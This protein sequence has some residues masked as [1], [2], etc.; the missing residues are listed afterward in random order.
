[1]GI[2]SR[3]SC[4]RYYNALRRRMR[5]ASVK[6]SPFPSHA[7]RS[8]ALSIFFIQILLPRINGISTFSLPCNYLCLF[9]CYTLILMN[10]QADF[11]TSLSLR[12]LFAVC[13]LLARILRC[14]ADNLWIMLRIHQILPYS[15]TGWVAGGT[16]L[17]LQC[18][19]MCF[20]YKLCFSFFILIVPLHSKIWSWFRY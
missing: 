17:K 4:S 6:Y 20:R 5:R 16:L 13:W 12:L 15:S 2:C 7:L 18:P 8:L 19:N 14:P 3:N 11:M 1:M 9:I 10:S